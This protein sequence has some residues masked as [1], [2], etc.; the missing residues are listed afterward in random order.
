[1]LNSRAFI[2]KVGDRQLTYYWVPQRGRILNNMFEQKAC[3]FWDSLTKRMTDGTL[4]R[5]MMPVSPGERAHE[6]EVR[7]QEITRR[8]VPVLDTFLPGAG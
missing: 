7:L 5:L 6:A 8:V 3:A 1:M 2:P 4:V